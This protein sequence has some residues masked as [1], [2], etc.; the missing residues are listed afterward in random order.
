MRGLVITVGLFRTVTS[1]S[2]SAGSGGTEMRDSV[3]RQ[4][5]GT[6][7]SG[8]GGAAGLTCTRLRHVTLSGV[9]T[10]TERSEG[11]S[12]TGPYGYGLDFCCGLGLMYTKSPIVTGG[13]FT[14][15][16]WS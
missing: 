13:R 9:F 5:L 2:G 16:F 4:V 3:A 11:V 12:T 10:I 15:A 8:G 14:P 1:E 6:K 7:V